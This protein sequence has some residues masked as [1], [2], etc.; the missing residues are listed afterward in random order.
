MDEQPENGAPPSILIVEDE[1]LVADFVETVLLGAGYAV[2]GI[3]AGTEAALDLARATRPALALVDIRLADGDD[4]IDLARRLHADTGTPA[5]FLSG[6]GDPETRARAATVPA[7]GF[8]QKPFR[9][10]QLVALVR[11]ALRGG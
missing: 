5:V 10:D 6:S 8:L 7:R 2:A 1:F 4:G 3:A 9:V 11:S